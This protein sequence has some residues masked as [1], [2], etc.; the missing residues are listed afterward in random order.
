V[1]FYSPTNRPHVPAE[2]RRLQ[3]RNRL[4]MILKNERASSLLRDLPHIALYELLA[5]GYAVLREPSLLPAY[6]QAARAAPRIW[7]KRRGDAAAP[8]PFGLTPSSIN[9][10]RGQ[11]PIKP[12]RAP[13]PGARTQCRRPG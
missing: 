9:T 10:K 6:W 3:F 11:T 2:H 7:R 13:D 1:R 5:L 4:L 8:V 12:P